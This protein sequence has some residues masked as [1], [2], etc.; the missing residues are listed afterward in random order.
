MSTVRHPASMTVRALWLFALLLVAGCASIPEQ[1][2][3]SLPPAPQTTETQ[4]PAQREHQRILA[5]YGGQYDDPKLEAVIS[6][7]VDRLVAASERP[8]L[9]YKVTLLNSPAVNAFALPGGSLYVTRGLI[10]LANDES[11]LASVLA[12][13]MAHVI[14]RHASIR[15]AQARQA[16]ILSAVVTDVLSDPNLG[17]LALAKSKLALANF[18]RA[19]EFEADGIGVG[20]AARAGFDPFGAPRFLT[21]MGHNAD[22]KSGSSAADPRATDFLSTHP[23]T[24]DRVKNALANARQFNAPGTA[25]E[26][27]RKEYIGLL[28]GLVYGE[29]PS[30]GFVRGRRF[31]HPKLGFTFQAPEGFTLDN[32]AQAV[33]GLKDGGNQALRLDVVQVPAE[34]TLDNYLVSGWMENVDPHS[35]EDFTVN[36]FPVAS[37]TAKGE[38]WSFRVFAVRFGSEVYRFIFA[39]KTLTPEADKSFRAAVSSF[40]RMSL[41]EA[42]AARP[43]KL[44]IVTVGPFDTVEKLASRMAVVSKPLERFR[45]LNGL[46]PG[47]AVKPGE[48]VKMV[49]E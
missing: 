20:I 2:Q 17:A 7:V 16:A 25:G 13:E 34:Q 46:E 31:L 40:R 37:A 26:R 45:V 42:E 48:K 44:K 36:G 33:L 23:S 12:H 43:L 38:Q 1:R 27:D 28:D 15:E 14:A 30:E 8:D 21:A 4:T 18:S 5:A 10:A 24:P 35:I 32:T 6:K 49:V 9:K 11:E 39:A 22:L 29:D 41:A 19:Q 47:Q 3:V